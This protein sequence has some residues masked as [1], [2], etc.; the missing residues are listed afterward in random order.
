MKRYSPGE[1][2]DGKVKMV[3]REDGDFVLAVRH[4]QA[5]AAAV[6]AERRRVWDVLVN[7]R[8]FYLVEQIDISP[9]EALA[10]AIKELFPEGEPKAIN[11]PAGE[12]RD[13]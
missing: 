7:R 3:E 2:I 8:R 5:I 11:P 4:E 12:R 10:I 9:D 6:T 1:I 13:D